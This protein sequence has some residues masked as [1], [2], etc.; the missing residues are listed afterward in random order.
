M[1]CHILGANPP[2]TVLNGFI[3]RIWKDIS[4]DRVLRM[5]KGLFRVRFANADDQQLVL[6]KE[7]VPFDNKPMIATKWNEDFVIDRAL[8]VSI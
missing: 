5:D 7:C 6:Q 1:Y 3:R 2:Y 8:E 4:I